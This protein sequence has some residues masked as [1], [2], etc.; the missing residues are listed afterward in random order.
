MRASRGSAGV[1]ATRPTT[2]SASS[3]GSPAQAPSIR[4]SSSRVSR[5]SSAE[6]VTRLAPARS[7][8]RQPRDVGSPRLDSPGRRRAPAARVAVVHHPVLR[9]GQPRREPA[10]HRAAAAAEVVDHERARGEVPREALGELGR[11]GRRVGRL[12]QVQPLRAD[13]TAAAVIAP[14]PRGRRRGRTWWPATRAATRAAPGRP[15][16]GG[17]AARRP[18]ASGAA[19]RRAPPGRRAGPAAP[20]GCRRRRARAPRSTPPTSAASTGTPRASASVTTMPY[21]SA[22]EAS[23]SRSAGGVRAV[24]LRAGARAREAHPVAQPV[25][26]RA[27]AHAVGERRVAVQAAHAGAA[28]G[29][30]GRRREP[31]EQHVVPL[32]GRDRRDAQQRV[33]GRGPGRE[34]GGVD[35]GLGHVHAVGRQLVQLLQ[36]APGP[37]AGRDDGGG[38]LEDRALALVAQRHVHEHD[39]PQAA[40]VRDERLGGGGRDQPVEQHHGAVRDPLEGARECRASRHGVL[41]HRPAERGEPFADP[42]VVRVAAARPR[43]VVDPLGD[44]EVDLASQRPLVARPCHVGLRKRH[45]YSIEARS[46]RSASASRSATTRASTSVVVLMPAKLRLVVEVAVA[47][48]GQHGA[49]RVGGAADVDHDAVGV[50]APRGGRWRRRRTS[51]RAGAA[52]ARTPRRGSCGRS[53]CGRGRSR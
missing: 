15:A 53:S 32:A 46:R 10:A 48:P 38:R 19:R 4:S 49:Q 42:A 9:P 1:S 18:R 2:V 29:Q 7:L 16:A 20:A 30:V 50:E 28:P 36:P 5:S 37:G 21:V 11:A 6:A 14:L 22:C 45:G 3:T 52:R 44:D 51:R 39:L 41:V 13:P 27:A 12:A 17:R 34:A 40:R 33:A 25:V 24:E 8:R 31:V 23:T 47:E 26:T 43:R 35:A